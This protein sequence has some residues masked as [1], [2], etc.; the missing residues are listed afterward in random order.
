MK[1]T[2]Y[3]S[4]QAWMVTKLN[5]KGA[6]RDIYA[7]LYGFTQ[8]NESECKCSYTYMSTITGYTKRAI[9]DAMD[10][11]LAKNLIVKSGSDSDRDMR[12]IYKCNFDY[13]DGVLR[14]GEVTSPLGGEVTSPLDALGGEVT[15]PHNIRYINNI[16][17][18]ST[19][20]GALSKNHSQVYKKRE[21]L[22]DDLESGKDIDKQKSDKRKSPKDKFK[23]ECLDI[24]EKEYSDETKDLLIEYFD[25]VTAVPEDK[26]NLCKRVKTVKQWRHKLDRLDDL[27]KDGYD[28]RKLIQQSLDKKQYVFYPLQSVQQYKAKRGGET[29][30]DEI[31]T[32]NVEEAQ[33]LWDEAKNSGKGEYC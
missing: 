9:M 1:D 33:R 15:S 16:H 10:R 23:D 18:K 13:I 2:N 27:V 5:L 26:S 21:S 11:L 14:G 29:L 25:F 24:I 32:T 17:N 7:I 19:G 3:F 6:E 20:D 31:V 30:C 28:C 12:N 8:D 4:V 22:N